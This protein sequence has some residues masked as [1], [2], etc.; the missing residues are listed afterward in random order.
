MGRDSW[1]PTTRIELEEGV[2]EIAQQDAE[3]TELARGPRSRLAVKEGEETRKMGRSTGGYC[4]AFLSFFQFFGLTFLIPEAVLDILAE[5][6]LS[7][8]QIL[9]NFIRHLIAFLV[10]AREEDLSFGLGEFRHLVLVKRN[11]HNPGTFLVSPPPGRHVIED[12]P[13]RDAKWHEQFF[14]FKV[15]Q[16]SVGNFDFFQLPRNW[17]ENVVF[18]SKDC[19]ITEDPDSVAH[20]VRHFKPAG[21]PLPS[22]RNMTERE[23]YV[24][25]AV[26]HAKAME[27]NNVSATTLEKH[28]QDVLRFDELYEIKKVFRELKLGLKMA[29]DRERAN[30]AQPAAAEKLGNQAASL[31][32]RLRDVSNERK[33]LADSYL[34]VLISLKER[35][36]KKKAAT[37]CE[38]CPRERSSSDVMA[39]SDFSV[40]KLDLPQISEG[41]P[42]NFFAKV[43]YVVDGTDDV[44]KCAGGQFEDGEFGIEE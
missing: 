21:C 2:T 10:R 22:L 31:E 26:A 1:R 32:V 13:Y 27:A 15:D 20:L 24:K 43:A 12:I 5:L 11:K 28:M 19:P 3:I 25:M 33:T 7:F 37:D 34:D 38:A 6:G 18:S 36:E 41:L 14:V 42:E 35:W 4:G 16:A 8:T 9:L 17:A 40:G 30:A 39:V 44:M 29:Q 23:A